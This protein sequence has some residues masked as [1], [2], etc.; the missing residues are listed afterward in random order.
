MKKQIITLIIA[1]II[2]SSAAFAYTQINEA[3]LSMYKDPSTGQMRAYYQPPGQ[4]GRY[5]TQ[6]E[7]NNLHP[8]LKTTY[9][10]IEAGTIQ[11]ILPLPP[12]DISTITYEPDAENEYKFYTTEKGDKR[13]LTQEEMSALKVNPETEH[14]IRQMESSPTTTLPEER[15]TLEQQQETPKAPTKPVLPKGISELG[16]IAGKITIGYDVNEPDGLTYYDEQGRKLT[17]EQ[18]LKEYPGAEEE[19]QYYRQEAQNLAK[20]EGFQLGTAIKYFQQFYGLAGW[21]S[22]IFDKEFLKKWK[23]KVNEIMCD[24]LHIGGTEC[25]A[26]QICGRYTDITPSRDGI[27][28]TP[29][30][31]GAPKATAHIEAQRS[32]PIITP[33]ATYWGYTVTFALT[34][35]DEEKEMTYNVVFGGER[36]A[37]WWSTPQTLAKGGTTSAIG[38]SALYKVSSTD[39]SEVCL[40]FDPEITSFGG[41]RVHKICNGIA[42][43]AGGPTAPYAV[44]TPT[45]EG[46]GAPATPGTPPP[47]ANV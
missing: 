17:L 1:I 9:E 39:Y 5:L 29:P 20:K 33:N 38:A 27:L 44:T 4:T 11:P 25:W 3:Y 47:G 26:S 42:Q 37:S 30:A 10:Q 8:L 31:G 2:S 13:E 18:V 22:L 35:P 32:L 15:V 24:T 41:K 16:K 21:S 23:D 43:Y 12:V 6:E 7:I 34:N 19:L 28:Y 36:T 40:V 46:P 45:T 14:I